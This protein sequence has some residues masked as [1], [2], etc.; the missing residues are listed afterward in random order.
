MPGLTYWKRHLIMRICIL[1]RIIPSDQITIV[2]ESRVMNERISTVP[3][4][5]VF[6]FIGSCSTGQ[7]TKEPSDPLVTHIDSTVK[8]G[9]DFFLYA[10]GKW[11][12]ENPIP[13]SEQSNGLWQLIQDTINAQIR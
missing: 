11:F 2:R 1:S 12:K 4:A 6:L 9:D 10:N 8:P 13:P 5:V 7:L 3:L